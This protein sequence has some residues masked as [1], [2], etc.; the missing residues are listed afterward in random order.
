MSRYLAPV[1]TAPMGDL[2]VNR[3]AAPLLRDLGLDRF[4]ALW[5]AEGGERV[6]EIPGRSV[7]RLPL[8][9]RPEGRALFVKRHGSERPGRR[10]RGRT[11]FENILA[12]RRAAIPTVIPVA[13]G[14]RLAH[15]C[16]GRSLVATLDV[17]PLV[18]LETL[19]RHR[20]DLFCD[21][22]GRSRREALIRGAAALA[23]RMHRAGLNHRDF[24]A[25]HLLL[26]SPEDATVP[27][28][29][30]FD[31]GGADRRRVL[32]W[33]WMVRSL[34]RL[35][36]TLPQPPFSPEDR[37]GLLLAYKEKASPGPLERLQR[38]WIDRKIGRIARHTDNIR[39][40]RRTSRPEEP[41][42]VDGR[43]ADTPS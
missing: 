14:E 42:V 34:A 33:R 12:F 24:N 27:D 21:P 30:L 4:E 5:R 32:R 15:G 40:R 36:Y 25:T 3:E 2:T 31:L 13:C 19:L 43:Y 28:L 6:K 7:V 18:P 20:P 11:E 10:S 39:R 17:H 41:P 8:P 29:A 35:A 16:D 37:T 26:G 22:E 38:F 9:G 1:E 23:R